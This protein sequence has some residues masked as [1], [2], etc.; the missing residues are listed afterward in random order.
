MTAADEDASI[1]GIIQQT[2]H[3]VA[4]FAYGVVGA[5]LHIF[6]DRTPVYL[7]FEHRK[8]SCQDPWWQRAQPS[9]MLDAR[10]EVVD[11]TGRDTEWDELTGWWKTGPDFRVRWLH[12]EGGQGKTRLA[13]RLASL[14]QSAGWK[15]ADAVHGTDT[16]PPAEGSQDLRLSGCAGL[17]LVV[18]YADRWPDSDLSW[19]L[20]NRLLRHDVP[21]RVLLIARSA[22]GWPAVENKVTKLR[23]NIDTSDQE[24][25]PLPRG[26]GDRERMFAV[27]RNCFARLYPG[28]TR[29]V[30]ITPP[31][32]LDQQEFG[33]V[34]AVH[35]A[36]LTAVDA[37]AHGRRAPTDMAGLTTY[38][39]HREQENWLQLYENQ[40]AGLDY[41]T[42]ANVMARTVFAATLIGPTN[43]QDGLRVLRILNIGLPPDVTIAAVV[44]DHAKC[45]QPTD[46]AGADVLQPLQ[47]DR[48][49][50]DFLA[51]T[52]EG[53][54]VS[55]YPADP[56]ATTATRRLLAADWGPAAPAWNR[57]A[58]TFLAAAA[59]RWTHVGERH[60]YPILEASPL[61]AREAGNAALTTIA[62][63]K[64]IPSRTLAAVE[65]T[66]PHG[67]S[68]DLDSG[69][70]AVTDRLSSRMPMVTEDMAARARHY[71]AYACRLAAVG[72]PGEAVH[73]A[74]RAVTTWKIAK[75]FTSGYHAYDLAEA[76]NIYAA[77]L[78]GLRQWSEMLDATQEATAILEALVDAHPSRCL[79][80][81][82]KVTTNQAIALSGLGRGDEAIECS[83]RNIDLLYTLV[84][85]L[86]H[87]ECVPSLARAAHNHAEKL[88]AAGL[89]GEALRYFQFACKLREELV[90]VDRAAHLA[91]F[92]ASVLA[93]AQ[94]AV[95]AHQPEAALDSGRRAVELLEEMAA[96][97]RTIH[98]PGLV[99]AVVSYSVTLGMAGRQDQ[100]ADYARRGVELG[101]QLLAGRP[102]AH[103][104][105]DL[106]AD[107]SHL[108][109]WAEQTER[110][111][112]AL[113]YSHRAVTFCEHLASYTTHYRPTLA[114]HLRIFA[115]IRARMGID[116]NTANH[117][118]DRAAKLLAEES[119]DMPTPVRDE[120]AD[121]FAEMFT[122]LGRAS[123]AEEIRLR[124]LDTSTG[125]EQATALQAEESAKWAQDNPD[126]KDKVADELRYILGG[127]WR[128]WPHG[129]DPPNRD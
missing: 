106:A 11:F 71:Q 52:L 79:P 114:H 3:A 1:P 93:H 129:G 103:H 9:R 26:G 12:G 4:G 20:Q 105:A 95:D 34:L 31:D 104:L 113:E 120:V 80:A 121:S 14:A 24:L 38:L 58:L 57:R 18:D 83:K 63:I 100:A 32:S 72:R 21:T 73:Y 91:D 51:L 89:H 13:N 81:L 6:G 119:A 29:P 122:L 46:P 124:L 49:A 48:L 115:C 16:H 110:R 107:I 82:A 101:E 44:A 76:L 108:A 56:W 33:L 92:A 127:S 117:A 87:S 55:G 86:G 67:R 5:D 22:H 54:P 25:P 111:P 125:A 112:E 64:N 43:R 36:A 77:A 17:L 128:H 68:L 98:L 15:A 123:D 8:V 10:A 66:L 90:K 85:K 96:A 61:I 42:P 88:V 53:S 47:P 59:E 65:R 78:S 118:A 74:Q 30:D 2:V 102:S 70:A 94:L 19:L 97:D 75:K 45:Y 28:I 41:R 35:M 50:E 69:A 126:W 109:L 84:V 62:T 37:R 27:A 60:L 39:L 116:L 7:L 99:N 23:E 40:V